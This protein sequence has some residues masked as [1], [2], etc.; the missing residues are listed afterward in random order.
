MM[1]GID[2]L[3]LAAAN[4][5]VL[6][7][8][9]AV[10]QGV[11]IDSRKLAN[12]DVFVA[13]RGEQS[14]GHQ[15]LASAAKRGAVGAVVESL[16]D[17]DIPQILVADTERALGVIAKLNRDAFKGKVVAITGSAGKTSCKNMLAAIL[18][19]VGSVCATA[20]NFNNEFGLPLTVQRLNAS[21]DFAVLE[22][23]AAKAGDIAYL[24]AIGQPHISAITNVGEAHIGGFGSLQNTAATKG[25]IYQSLAA[26]GF[27][28]INRDDGFADFWRGSLEQKLDHSHLIECSMDDSQANIYASDIRQT[29]SGIT[30]TAHC[31][32]ASETSSHALD[33]QLGFLGIHN[34]NN[35]LMA[36]A[37]AK[38]LSVSDQHIV[39]GLQVAEAESGRLCPL[40]GRNRLQ[41]LDDSYN[42]SPKAVCAAVDVLVA[43]CSGRADNQPALSIAVLADMGELGEEAEQQHNNIGQY[44]AKAGVTR[45]YAIGEFASHTVNAF[46]AEASV[47]KVTASETTVRDAS[48]AVF[49]TQEEII[50]QLLSPSCAGANVLIKG[51][52]FTKM[53]N[54][55]KALDLKGY[56]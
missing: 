11:C 47:A 32:L 15:Y 28:I 43:L 53:E 8:E 27:A 26:D 21:H 37:I 2:L 10:V 51:S 6:H 31:K 30:F 36:I 33:I 1:P 29:S 14:D 40:A 25:E 5:A 48:A 18:A 7:G 13:L 45:L 39:A 23:G 49:A 38:T 19:Q 41:L 56:K 50:E 46:L 24:A 54:I 16:Q 4:D 42:A 9:N 17:A 44:A 12:G 55:V 34:V 3:A 22:M 35:A 52:R 20:G